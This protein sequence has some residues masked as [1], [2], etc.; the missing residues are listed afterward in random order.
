MKD[1]ADMEDADCMR[2]LRDGDDLALNEIM[3]RWQQKIAN[4]LM[5]CLGSEADALDLTQETFVRVYENRK[6]YEARAAF[7]SWLFRIATNLARDQ[8]RWRARHP[9]VSIETMPGDQAVE[10]PGPE[11]TGAEALMKKERARAVRDAVRQLHVDFRTVLVLFE[12]EEMSYQQIAM[13]LDCSAK[14]VESR[15]YRA[16]QALRCELQVRNPHLL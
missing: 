1:Y 15:L 3:L 11:L 14:A 16:K 9:A 8:I 12:Y 4:Y 2:R 13:I 6:K 10:A 7:S 5:R